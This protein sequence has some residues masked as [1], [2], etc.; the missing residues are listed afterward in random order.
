VLTV[1]RPW[2][3][4]AKLGSDGRQAY[5]VDGAVV[6]RDGNPVRAGEFGELGSRGENVMLEYC[7]EP[8]QAANFFGNRWGW[9]GDLA[10]VEEVGFVA[11]VDRSK[12]MIISGG[13]NV[14]PKEIENVLYDHEAVSECAVFGLTDDNWGEVPAAYIQIKAGMEVSEDDLVTHCAERLARFKRPR[15]VKF[16]AEFPKT[17]IGKIQKNILREPYW[18]DREKKI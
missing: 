11:L 10:T 14:Y 8:E 18:K 12:D 4:T 7:K 2:Y 6:G 17:P 1:L 5:N 15:V 3:Q 13:E 9:A 16:V